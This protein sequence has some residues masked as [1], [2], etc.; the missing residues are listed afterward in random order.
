MKRIFFNW[1]ELINWI[2]HI[3]LLNGL[4]NKILI[5]TAQWIVGA[6]WNSLCSI[7]IVNNL[8]NCFTSKQKI[9]VTALLIVDLLHKIFLLY[10]SFKLNKFKG[11]Y[12]SRYSKDNFVT[13]PLPHRIKRWQNGKLWCLYRLHLKVALPHSKIMF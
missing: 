5:V 3:W 13:F 9:I 12:F 10:C 1:K 2:N 4:H 11:I 8:I 7:I 6:Q